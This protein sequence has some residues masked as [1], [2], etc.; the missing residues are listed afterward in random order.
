MLAGL[1]SSFA[2]RAAVRL[3]RNVGHHD[4][5]SAMSHPINYWNAG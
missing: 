3:I 5:I 1:G 4:L 2:R